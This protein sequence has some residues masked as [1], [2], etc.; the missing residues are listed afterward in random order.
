VGDAEA[1]TDQQAFAIDPIRL[2]QRFGDA[3]SH[4]L[5]AL[6]RAAGVDQQGKFIAAQPRQLI[7]CFELTFQSRYYL[8][9]QTIAGLMAEGVVGA[10]EVVQVQ[11]PQ[12]QA[13]AVVFGQARGEQG[14]ETLTVGDAGQRILF[15]ETLQGVF[16]HAAFTHM[17]QAAAQAC[18]ASTDV[19]HQPVA[20]ANRRTVSGRRPAAK[21]RRQAALTAECQW[22]QAC[23]KDGQQDRVAVVVRTNCLPTSQLERASATAGSPKGARHSRNNAEP[24]RLFGQ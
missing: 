1:A 16:Q 17:A 18:A 5:G 4:P 10:A 9:D 11:M 6:R 12:G 2:G 13:A 22:T 3:F 8:Q 20:D 19:A 14:L 7:A 21:Y 23:E 15:G 24:R